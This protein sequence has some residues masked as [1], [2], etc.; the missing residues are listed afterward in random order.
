MIKQMD[1][2]E[3]DKTGDFI[4]QTIEIIRNAEAKR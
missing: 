1:S 2:Q 3:H 4:D